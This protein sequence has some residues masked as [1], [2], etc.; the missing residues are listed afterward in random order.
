MTNSIL[1][2]DCY[3]LMIQQA[4]LQKFPNAIARYTFINKGEHKFTEEMVKEANKRIK[5]MKDTCKLNTN[6][7]NWLKETCPFFTTEYLNYLK[8]Y[9]FDPNKVSIKLN[10]DSKL[11]ISIEDLMV[12]SALWEVPIITILSEVYHEING[13]FNYYNFNAEIKKIKEKGKELEEI[14]ADFA[15]FGTQHR[16]SKDHQEMVIKT[17]VETCH[18]TLIG[19]SNLHLACK[20][21]IKPIRAH[22]HEWF[23]LHAAKYGY[24]SANKT[25]LDNWTNIYGD[26]IGI[27]IS[28][29][30]TTDEFFR[31][32]DEQTSKAYDGLQHNSGD[33]ISF[34]HR[35]NNHYRKVGINPQNKNIVFS[36]NL[37]IT[38]IK[39]IKKE[40]EYEEGVS[41]SFNI[42]SYL[43][44][45]IKEVKIANIA[46][47]LTHCKP[48]GRKDKEWINC[49]KLSDSPLQY[50]GEKKAINLCL[51]QIKNLT[52]H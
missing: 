47:E 45:N 48:K 22:T 20:Y 4:L 9:R 12:R 19:T 32:F 35:T 50:G 2:T 24:L 3:K 51:L 29:T 44:C 46:I 34:M 13:D 23:M 16:F 15:V 52:K 17:L 28:D 31:T 10:K 7:Y 6:E 36:N 38:S 8:N 33:P 30:F 1:D 18:N 40:T 37:N 25:A 39:F 14:G 27:A 49:V 11:T 21:N 5:G 41:C 26:H 43:T 42:G